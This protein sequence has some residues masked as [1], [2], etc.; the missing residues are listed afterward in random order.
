MGNK[1]RIKLCFLDKFLTW[2]NTKRCFSC[3]KKVPLSEWTGK[4]VYEDDPYGGV[5]PVEETISLCKDCY[6]KKERGQNKPHYD[7]PYTHGGK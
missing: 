3:R 5:W 6:P 1:Y 4:V 2:L 7:G